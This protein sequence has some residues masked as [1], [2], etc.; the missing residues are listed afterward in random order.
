MSRGAPVTP[1]L[2]LL[3]VTLAA[4]RVA[5]AHVSPVTVNWLLRTM[6]FFPLTST[7]PGMIRFSTIALSPALIELPDQVQ[8]GPELTSCGTRRSVVPAATPVLVASGYPQRLGRLTQL[9]R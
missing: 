6:T 5:T 2:L 3:I 1:I 4:C 7:E 8:P 9:L